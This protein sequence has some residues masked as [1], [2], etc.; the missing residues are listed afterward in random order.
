MLNQLLDYPGV[1]LSMSHFDAIVV[2]VG[3]HGSA[4]LYQLAKKGKKV[5]WTTLFFIQTHDVMCDDTFRAFHS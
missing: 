3:G 1:Y 2:G 4:A 5:L